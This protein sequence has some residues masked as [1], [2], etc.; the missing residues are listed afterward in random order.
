[1]PNY[2]P[3][4][5]VAEIKAACEAGL[6][7]RAIARMTGVATNT[8]RR[9]IPTAS[10]RPQR[11]QCGA[12]AGHQGWCKWRYARSPARQAMHALRRGVVLE[13]PKVESRSRIKEA[14][15][16]FEFVFGIADDWQKRATPLPAEEHYGVIGE[17]HAATRRVSWDVRDD[18]RQSMILAVYEGRVLRSEIADL[19]G[20]FVKREK[21]DTIGSMWSLYVSLNAPCGN[22]DRRGTMVDHLSRLS[23]LDEDG[24][25]RGTVAAAA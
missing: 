18:V 7:L 19:V 13:I 22:S 21:R 6:S 12:P 15:A 9:Y 4:E 17:V 5:V 8:V 1:M 23:E 20:A 10:A 3:V 16:R 14:R 25:W 24:V 11:C 2:L